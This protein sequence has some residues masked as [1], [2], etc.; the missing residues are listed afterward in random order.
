MVDNYDMDNIDKR[1]FDNQITP[2]AENKDEYLE[3]IKGTK[4]LYTY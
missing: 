1:T 4:V 3:L 2:T